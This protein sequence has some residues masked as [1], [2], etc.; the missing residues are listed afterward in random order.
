MN[1]NLLDARLKLGEAKAQQAGHVWLRDLCR[2]KRVEALEAATEAAPD[3]VRQSYRD[4][5]KQVRR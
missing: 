1:T 2:R 4:K 5:R 3:R